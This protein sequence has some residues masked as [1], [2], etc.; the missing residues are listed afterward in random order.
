MKE[1]KLFKN[2]SIKKIITALLLCVLLVT[3][4]APASVSA[5]TN[6]KTQDDAFNW[7]GA[8][9]NEHW[10]YSYGETWCVSLIVA[11]YNWLGVG[12]VRG[13][14]NEYAYNALPSGWKRVYSDPQPGDIVVWNAGVSIGWG[15]SISYADSSYGH[16]GLVVRKNSWGSITTVETRARQGHGAYYYERNP[17]SAACFIRPDFAAA[18]PAP[19]AMNIGQSFDALIIRSDV[20]MPIYKRLSDGNVLLGPHNTRAYARN[21]WHFERQADGSYIITSLQDG[22]ALD[23]TGASSANGTNVGTYTKW[24]T[25]NGAQKWYVIGNAI[26]YELAPKLSPDKR[27]DVTGGYT[28]VDTNIEIYEA[29]GTNAQIFS[30]YKCSSANGYPTSST[31]I[32]P[33]QYTYNKKVGNSF[34]IKENFSSRYGASYGDLSW[35]SSNSSV[36]SVNSK[37]V[38]TAKKQGTAQITMTSI[39][40]PNIS[41][42]VKVV[43]GQN[44]VHSWNS[45]KI[46]VKPTTTKKGVKTYTCKKCGATKKVSV[47]V[48]SLVGKTVKVKASNGVY[49]VLKNNCVEFTKPITKKATVSIPATVKISGKTYKVVTISANAFKNNTVLRT[50]TIGSNVATIRANAFYGCRNL[51]KITIRSSKLTGK[52]VGT[53]AFAKTNSKPTVTVPAKK[54]SSYKSLLRSR[55]M[56]KKAIYKK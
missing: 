53:N 32:V 51:K 15:N 3:G 8:R 52:N 7:I 23:V 11:Y 18:N 20:W 47:P 56:S 34:Q 30:I 9:G 24:G 19:N 5:T 29:N 12:S 4:A 10:T 35:K 37:G 33:D 46:T 27:L 6:G 49:K 40:N 44:H 21:H 38:V 28:T 48:V 1:K 2:S 36:A 54:L 22:K 16:V 43:V 39:F 31:S 17:Q 41:T 45:G 50:L 25:D 13:N 55:G 42:T 26:A 14:A